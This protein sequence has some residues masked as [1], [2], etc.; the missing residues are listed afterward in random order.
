MSKNREY[1][2]TA[3]NSQS[4]KNKKDRDSRIPSGKWMLDKIKPIPH[5]QILTQC[6]EMIDCTIK[7]LKRHGVFRMPVDVAIDKHL[8]P[9]YDKNPDMTNMINSKTQNGTYHYNCLATINCT[10]DGSRAFLGAVI[11]R[12]EDFLR[13]TIAELVDGCEKNGIKIRVLTMDRE[14]FTVDVINMLKSKNIRFITP[15]T[16]TKG[17]KDAVNEFETDERD[18]V[19]SHFITSG[20][21]NKTKAEFTIIMLDRFDRKGQKITRPF[22]TDVPVNIVREFKYNGKVG[23]EAFVDQY[24]NRWSIETGYRCMKEMRPKTTS[25]NESIR[26]LLLFMPIILFNV[27]VMILCLLQGAVIGKSNVSLTAKMMLNFFIK[28]A[29]NKLSWPVV[30]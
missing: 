7:R 2:Q 22:A 15:A 14:F 21:G 3:Y 27:W 26:V 29:K 12:R 1:A 18:A 19:S 16:R 8:I 4:P 5:N 23:A 9:R 24:R 11:F 6:L 25:R 20:D 30:P 17:V 28:F 13:D 10:E